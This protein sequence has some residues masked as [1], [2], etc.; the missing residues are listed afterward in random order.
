MWPPR[1]I[2]VKTTPIVI[3]TAMASSPHVPTAA[4]HVFSRTC[5]TLP[6]RHLYFMG[7]L[8]YLAFLGKDRAALL[9]TSHHP[10]IRLIS[11]TYK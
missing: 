2:W 4:L 5:L 9:T 6:S 3:L 10:S 11:I 1:P 7:Y 8:G